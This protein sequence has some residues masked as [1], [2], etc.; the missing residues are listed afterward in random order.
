MKRY[1]LS[2]IM[3]RAHVIAKYMRLYNCNTWG[4]C[5]RVAWAQEKKNVQRTEAAQAE[6][7]AMKAA[8]AQPIQRS[9]YDYFNAP[10]S[11][12]YNANSYG[13]LGSHYVGD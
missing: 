1:N 11:A 6:K 2:Q 3:K 8:L 13:H 9:S 10:T 4:D 7:E 5:L 12:Y